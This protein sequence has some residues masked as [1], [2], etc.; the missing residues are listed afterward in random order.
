MAKGD[1]D[2]NRVLLTGFS[3]GAMGTWSVAYDD[4]TRFAAIVPVGGRTGDK[5]QMPLI[6]GIPAW[7]FNGEADD[8]TT[9]VMARQAVADL[10]AAGGEVKYTEYPGASH[11]DSLSM[12][13]A[14]KELYFWLA[15]RK[16]STRQ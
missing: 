13:Y 9:A 8:A 6:K 14:E 12:A 1:F 5:R 4:P 7:V 2:P 15:Q 16:R 11:V 3:M 10:K